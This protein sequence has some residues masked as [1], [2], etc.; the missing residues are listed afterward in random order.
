MCEVLKISRVGYYR[1]VKRQPREEDAVLI[2]KIETLFTKSRKTY[3]TRRIKKALEKEEGWIVS[4]RRI[5]RI[6]RQKGWAVKSKPRFKPKTTDSNH[7]ETIA[8]NLLQRDFKTQAPNQAY[9]GD[10]TYIPTQ[11]GWIYL[12]TVIDLYSRT[13]VGWAIDDSMHTTLITDALQTASTKRSTMQGAIFHSDRGSQ[14]ASSTFKQALKELGMQQS[15]SAKGDCWDNAVAESFF[16]S[17]KT[18]WTQHRTYTTKKEA[19]E[20]IAEYMTFYNRT[21]LHSYNN[22]CSP[23]EME[24]RWWQNQRKLA[25]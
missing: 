16:H 11:Q 3:G 17:L 14:Y 15:M 9:V 22:Y 20:D 6:M 13:V 12:A 10:I 25:A 4:R 5:G 24:M 7:N 1:W 21:R 18:E 8:P 19:M 2:E 23:L